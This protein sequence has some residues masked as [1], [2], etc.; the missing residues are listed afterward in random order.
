MGV[1]YINLISQKKTVDP[2]VVEIEEKS[3]I[4]TVVDQKSKSEYTSQE[5]INNFFIYKYVQSS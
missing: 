4:P 2:F 1:V 3:G 5:A